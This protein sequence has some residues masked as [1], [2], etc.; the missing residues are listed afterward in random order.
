MASDFT[1]LSKT[2]QIQVLGGYGLGHYGD[3]G[4]GEG[5]DVAVNTVVMTDWTVYTTK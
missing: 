5:L 3:E 4:Y 2:G 1:R